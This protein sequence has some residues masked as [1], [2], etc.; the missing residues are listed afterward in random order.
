M[1]SMF[2]SNGW[3]AHDIVGPLNKKEVRAALLDYEIE[4]SSF[5]T[6]DSIEEMVLTSSDEVKNVLYESGLAKKKVEEEA[7]KVARK[8]RAEARAMS[9]NVRRRIGRE[10]F[11]II[12]RGVDC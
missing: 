10:I 2:T 5:R 9:R 6:W 3:T 8:R 1:A 7:E 11:Y 4:R 12:E